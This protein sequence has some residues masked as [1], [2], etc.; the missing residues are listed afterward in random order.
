MENKTKVGWNFDNSYARLPEVFFSN[1][2]PTSVR[3]PKLIILNDSLAASL[4]LD[5]ETLKSEEGVAV[6]AGNQLPEGAMPLAQAYAGHQ[7]GHF[8]MLGDGRAVLLG[9]QITSSGERFDIQL[10]GS[11]RTPYSRGG[12]G[13]AT[14]G[15]MLREYIISEAMHGL[16]IP[17][18]RSLAVVSTGEPVM[19]EKELPGAV[20]T[21]VAA[22]HIRFGTFQYVAKWGSVEELK[23]LADYTIERHYPDIKDDGN[24]YLTL[25][26][27]VVQRKA[28]L[29]AKWQQ[30]GFIHGVM[31]TDNM[32]LSGETIDYGPCAFMDTY[33]P[34]TVFSSIDRQGR[35]AFGNQPKIAA[36]NLARFAE[37]L[38][39][40]IHE[41][42]DEAV[43]LA[44]NE[45]SRFADHFRIHWL[46][47]MRAKLG[48][49]HEEE[50]D[51]QLIENLLQ[52]M[53]KYHADYTNTFLALTFS[54]QEG[55]LFASEEFADWQKRWHARR[56]R[57]QESKDASI[58]LMKQSNPAVI[59]RN[60]R[61]EEALAAAVEHE[62]YS[63]MNQLLA[64]LANPYAH[65][66][67]QA[68][69]ST[70][71]ESTTQ[72][73]QTFCGT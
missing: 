41:D 63:V 21:R 11:G 51:E 38:L 32:T 61:V 55:E 14:V 42:Q 59:P 31:N 67:E 37:A 12:D 3:S 34:E 23:T 44:Q 60:H 30:V 4:G 49:F 5:V 46:T 7:F 62:D 54:K 64:V 29:I 40:L 39:A 8:T 2:E 57:Q 50:Q 27:Q 47:G 71:P 43:T 36:W 13:R 28:M 6:Q 9:E 35:Y 16:G 18:T 65:S 73:Y 19:R 58:D 33:D 72:P 15:P 45:I 52:L 66:D 24:R 69:Y 22:S 53:D 68:M 20:L 48:I 26:Q 1:T 10:K 17:T 70:L 25:L 56:E